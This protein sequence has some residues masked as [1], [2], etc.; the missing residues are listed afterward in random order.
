MR[1][2]VKMNKRI[3]SHRRTVR[4]GRRSFNATI[5]AVSGCP[6]WRQG[7]AFFLPP[8]AIYRFIEFT[9]LHD[10]I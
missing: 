6:Q 5:R 3:L 7:L 1:V 10:V 8:F 4:M 2:N 9:E